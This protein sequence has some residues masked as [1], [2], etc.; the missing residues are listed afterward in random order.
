MSG[1]DSIDLSNMIAKTHTHFGPCAVYLSRLFTPN[2]QLKQSMLL[3]SHCSKSHGS[4][5]HG[6]DDKS[7]SS[8][9]TRA[10]FSM[11]LS[12]LKRHDIEAMTVRSLGKNQNRKGTHQMKIPKGDSLQLMTNL[13]FSLLHIHPNAP[14][15]TYQDIYMAEREK[16]WACWRGYG[17]MHDVSL[18]NDAGDAYQRILHR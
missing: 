7:A 17:G 11:S 13:L 9:K 16:R 1:T 4:C 6:G 8:K 2:L 10:E 5:L 14:L 18:S 15:K 12:R 3:A